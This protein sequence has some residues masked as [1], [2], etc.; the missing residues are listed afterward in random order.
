[1]PSIKDEFVSDAHT[2]LRDLFMGSI[3][4]GWRCEG[5]VVVVDFDNVGSDG[6][7]GIDV[8]T[9]GVCLRESANGS[10]G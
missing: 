5:V 10:G 9:A 2:V 4:S 6:G 3:C 1:M 8:A 7:I